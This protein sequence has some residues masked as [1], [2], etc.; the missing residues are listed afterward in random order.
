MS[1][2]ILRDTFGSGLET[3]PNIG[4]EVIDDDQLDE[5]II[6]AA[7]IIAEEDG[8]EDLKSYN[9]DH[10]DLPIEETLVICEFKAMIRERPGSI[11]TCSDYIRG[12]IKKHMD[13]ETKEQYALYLKLKE[14]FEKDTP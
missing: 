2:I 7:E 10:P 5:W 11:T 12:V 1:Y 9:N 6:G 13:K 14:K 3:I 8:Y 4:L